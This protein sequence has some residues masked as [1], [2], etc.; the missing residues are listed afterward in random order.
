MTSANILVAGVF[1]LVLMACI[2]V[3]SLLLGRN[4]SR[5]RELAMRL[6]MGA[7]RWQVGRQV[8]VESLIVSLGASLLGLIIAS[9]AVAGMTPLIPR[10]FP[11]IAQ[12]DIDRGVAAFATVT[13]VVT[14]LL[15]SVWPAW[16]ASRQDYGALM[17]SGERG[18]SG[19][20][21]RIRGTLVVFEATLAMVVLTAAAL[22]V[23]SFNRLNPREPGFAFANRTKC[24]VRLAGP[25]YAEPAARAAAVEEISARLQA[26]PGVI[27]ASSAT[28]VPLTGTSTVFPARV[29]D[30]NSA[31]VNVHFRAVLPNY[32]GLMGMPIVRGHGLAA[33]GGWC[34]ATG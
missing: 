30:A 34:F 14:G 6:A 10:W 9:W 18:S 1:L 7:S 11:R 23:G 17:K 26:L 2:N 15:V 33:S 32:L 16:S 5:R 13:A 19:A 28:H 27:D 3:A 25:R 31:P 24:S 20:A 29:D 4:V 22:L 12:I 8:A 21:S